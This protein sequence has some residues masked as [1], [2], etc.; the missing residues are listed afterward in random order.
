VRQ[1]TLPFGI[2][3]VTG[4]H[5]GKII[6]IH[7]YDPESSVYVWNAGTNTLFPK[8]NGLRNVRISLERDGSLLVSQDETYNIRIFDVLTGGELAKLHSPSPEFSFDG[9]YMA[10][11]LRADGSA[12]TRVAV[13]RMARSWW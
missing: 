5:D 10:G 6:A 8:I 3:T 12:Q 13:W 11:V 9:R 7:V 1:L 4:S 2:E